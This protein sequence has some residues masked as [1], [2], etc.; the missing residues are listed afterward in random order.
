MAKVIFTPWKHRS[1][2][3]A[4]RGQFYPAPE[5]DGPDMRPWACATVGAWKLRGNLPHPVEA[6]ALLTDAILHD[7]ARKNSVFSIRATY[8]AAFCRFVTGLVDSKLYTGGARKTMFARAMELGLPASFVE[9]RHEATHR[10]LPSLTVLRNSTQRSL[11]W[12]WDFYWGRAD[13]WTGMQAACAIGP[14]VL[15]D[16]SGVDGEEALRR[17]LRGLLGS[18]DGEG[19]AGDGAGAGL[20]RKK[21]KVQRRLAGVADRVISI[22]R[23]SEVGSVALAQLLLR[24]GILITKGRRL[25]DSFAEI[26]TKWEPLLQMIAEGHPPFLATLIEM[27]VDELAFSTSPDPERDSYCEGVYTWLDHILRSTRWESQRRTVSYSY[28]LAVCEG[29]SNHW[30]SL[31]K[32]NIDTEGNKLPEIPPSRGLLSRQASDRDLTLQDLDEDLKTLSKYGWETADTWDS[33]PLGIA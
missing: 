10:E 8:S 5:Y 14:P 13:T 31:L 11:E 12:L 28:L 15:D 27:M 29:S 6:T 30:T 18:V 3:L 7:D 16:G 19:L 24:E 32:K 23:T 1:E 9:L 25:G 33:R 22:L 26:I 21:R 20:S 4:V 17:S 2:L